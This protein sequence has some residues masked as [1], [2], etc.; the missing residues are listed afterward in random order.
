MSSRFWLSTLAAIAMLAGLGAGPAA[1]GWERH[2]DRAVYHRVYRP[3]YRHVPVH[4]DRYAYRPA[5][6]RYYPY[7]NSNYWRPRN[8]I[9]LYRHRYHP[10]PNY[11]SSWGYPLHVKHAR[12]RP[13]KKWRHRAPRYA[14]PVK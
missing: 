12:K 14:R 7:Y 11:W 9:V 13:A 8:E 4:Y 10:L 5:H 2:H 3:Y 6:V 1:A